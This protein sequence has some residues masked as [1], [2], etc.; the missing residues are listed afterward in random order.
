VLQSALIGL[1][2]SPNILV[3]LL[4]VIN[5]FNLI[6]FSLTVNVLNSGGGE[7]NPVMR[8]LFALGPV[9]AGIFKVL[10][11]GGATWLVW[12]CRRFR[13]VLKVTIV[14]AVLFAV[15]LVYHIFGLVV[16]N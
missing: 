11:V 16:F 8:S 3:A 6:D 4:L 2:D 15:V 1:R 7:A 5:I 13:C 10:A 14:V 9:W 12:R